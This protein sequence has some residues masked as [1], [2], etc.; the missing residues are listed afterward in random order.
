[1]SLLTRISIPK[2]EIARRPA[3]ALGCWAARPGPALR[4]RASYGPVM[5]GCCAPYFCP[6]CG[7]ETTQ[8]CVH[9][10]ASVCVAR[11]MRRRDVLSVPLGAWLRRLKISK[12]VS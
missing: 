11:S 3:P 12:G 10:H 9:D 4:A 6:R 2:F 8:C 1:M 7:L 5:P